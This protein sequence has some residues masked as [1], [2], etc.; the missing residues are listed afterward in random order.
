MSKVAVSRKKLE[1]HLNEQLEFL[2]RSAAAF[3]EGFTDE[4]KRLATVVR[5]LVHDTRTSHSLLNQLDIKNVDFHD[6]AIALEDGNKASEYGLLQIALGENSAGENTTGFFA[7]LDG[8]FF[9]SSVRF[10]WAGAQWLG[11]Y[12]ANNA[13]SVCVCICR[14]C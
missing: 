7:P 2:K 10:E 12:A 14:S 11:Q 13:N 9:S 1:E 5:V 4:A 3:D 8:A 6:T